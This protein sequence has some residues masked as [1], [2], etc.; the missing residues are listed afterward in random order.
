VASPNNGVKIWTVLELITWST[1]HLQE[2]NIDEARLTVE[3]LLGHAL[4]MKRIQL[5]MNF[6]KPM[7][8][9]ELASYKLLLKRRLARE[10]VQYI[11]GETEFMGLPFSVDARVL[12]PR[13]ETETLVE[14][15]LRCC[16]SLC[17]DGSTLAVLDIGT[18][19]GCIAVSVAK[20]FTGSSVDAIDISTD[21]LAVA[22]MNAERNGVDVN[23]AAADIL[24]DA[25][26]PFSRTYDVIL[27]NPPYISSAVYATLEPE[28]RNFEPSVAETDGADG[29][30]FYR[31]LAVRT[32]TMLNPH[33]VLAVEHAFDQQDDV[34]ALFTAA[35]WRS[36]VP[37]SDTSGNPRC[38]IVSDVV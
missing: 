31:R 7:T 17:T 9:E 30:S 14:E 5:Y 15:A 16:K 32:R 18:G 13:P 19:S 34:M 38:V 2:K 35:G 22:R 28:I 3:L 33:G 24:S 20:L 25:Q 4:K 10:P 8:A 21:A 11:I 29:L 6:D 1:S 36:V 12:I 26:L 27:S 23:F 37:V